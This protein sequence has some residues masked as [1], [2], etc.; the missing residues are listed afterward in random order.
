[1]SRL[2]EGLWLSA[3]V[4]EGG[5][6][7][8]VARTGFRRAEEDDTEGDKTDTGLVER[9]FPLPRMRPPPSLRADMVADVRG[10][11]GSCGCVSDQGD[12]WGV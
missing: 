2:L 6:W 11:P 7:G 3:E 1:M 8:E 5:G 4:S 10:G 12:G 9:P